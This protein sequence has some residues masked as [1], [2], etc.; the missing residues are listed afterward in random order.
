MPSPASSG[1]LPC[2]LHGPVSST[3]PHGPQCFPWA[4][5]LRPAGTGEDWQGSFHLRMRAYADCCY[6]RH[7]IATF[8]TKESK[9]VQYIALVAPLPAG[10]GAGIAS[11][12][13]R[14]ARS[15]A[16]PAGRRWCRT[17]KPAR[18]QVRRQRRISRSL[19]RRGLGQA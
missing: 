11:A 12:R 9:N 15:G 3:P 6:S 1:S 18:L 19:Q 17:G 4:G 16:S 8:V 7:N 2:G 13:G 5:R 10:W 14:R